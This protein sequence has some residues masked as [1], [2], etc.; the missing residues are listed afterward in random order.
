MWPEMFHS[1]LRTRSFNIVPNSWIDLG[2]P[3]PLNFCAINGECPLCGI[4]C[5]SSNDVQ[6]VVSRFNWNTRWTSI[7]PNPIAS[8]LLYRR[9]LWNAR[10]LWNE[11]SSLAH[12]FARISL[13]YFQPEQK[14]DAPKD[15]DVPA[16]APAPQ[17]MCLMC[18]V[19]SQVFSNFFFSTAIPL[20]SVIHYYTLHLN[21]VRSRA[22]FLWHFYRPID[23]AAAGF[24]CKNLYLKKYNSHW[25]L[26]Y[27]YSLV[28]IT[29]S[30]S[31]SRHVYFS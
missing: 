17:V 5:T 2:S 28:A 22:G 3:V 21:A 1:W 16:N 27:S 31:K 18:L 30:H 26:P 6:R 29:K 4:V 10:P 23:I 24:T 7:S 19:F 13:Y 8:R 11:S 12:T 25:H 9:G 20:I 15:Q 14:S